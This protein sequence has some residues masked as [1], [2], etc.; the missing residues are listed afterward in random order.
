MLKTIQPYLH[1]Q[2][3]S[4]LIIWGGVF[5]FLLLIIIVFRV[6]AAI[7]LRKETLADAITVVRVMKA[8]QEKG[9]DKIILP[10]NVQ[11]WHESPVFARTNGYV[12]KWYVDIGSRVKKGDLLA[13]IETPELDAQERQAKADLKTAIANN[14]LAQITAKRWLNL[15]KTES[16]SQQE[17]DEK[18]STAA[19]LDAAVL[20]AKANLQRL[21]ELVGFERVI[22]P[23]DGVI[24]D[25]ATDI[26]DLIDAGSST[27]AR[28]LFRIAQTHPLRIYVKIPQYYSS[29]IKPAMTVNL[30]FAEHPKQI[31][32]AKLFETAHAIDP[33]TR[34]LLAQFTSENK[35]GELLPGGYTEVWFTL[36]IPPKTVILPVNT[37]LFRAQGLQV[38]ALDKSNKVTLKSVTIRRDFGSKVEIATGVSPGDRIV[39][40]PPD[41]IRDGEAVR[42]VL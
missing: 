7:T 25:R 41:A 39:V 1:N 18:V 42:V 26:G 21:Q 17:T 30:H 33:Q 13:V 20:S 40:N 9:V 2:R 34:T 14:K 16:V 32:P 24:T 11:A 37:L 10:G 4:R 12:K 29:R 28:P 22:A 19:A 6:Y 36:P 35:E 38:A 15:V 23:F 5:L 31:F 8:E 3:P 27:T